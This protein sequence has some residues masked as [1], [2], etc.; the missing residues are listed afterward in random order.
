MKFSIFL[1]LFLINMVIGVVSQ[2]NTIVNPDIKGISNTNS[3][4]NMIDEGTTDVVSDLK[5]SCYNREKKLYEECSEEKFNEDNS[6]DTIFFYIIIIS[7]FILI[8]VIIYWCVYYNKKI[9]REELNN[10]NN[11]SNTSRAIFND[12]DT[13][14]EYK[15][16]LIN[17]CS[18]VNNSSN[19]EDSNFISIENNNYH[20]PTYEESMANIY[21]GR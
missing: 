13:L 1:L 11:P 5:E 20:L 21:N 9:K 6:I 17:I 7:P 2:D 19:A 15:E 3:S 12:N 4:I 8:I 18:S 16:T 10:I 14:P